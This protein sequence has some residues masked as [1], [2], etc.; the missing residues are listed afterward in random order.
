MTVRTS[1]IDLFLTGNTRLSGGASN[2]R[3]RNELTSGNNYR[4]AI[5]LEASEQAFPFGDNKPMC[6]SMQT[7]SLSAAAVYHD[8][9]TTSETKNPARLPSAYRGNRRRLENSPDPRLITVGWVNTPSPAP[10]VGDHL[11]SACP[12][13]P[14]DDRSLIGATRIHWPHRESVP[15]KRRYPD[16]DSRTATTERSDPC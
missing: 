2:R 10:R 7:S 14:A 3:S 16:L 8:P 15:C 13:S 5:L 1:T 6:S 4:E 12:T 9:R 11:E